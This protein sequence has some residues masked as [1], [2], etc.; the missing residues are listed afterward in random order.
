[1]FFAAVIPIEIVYASETLDAGSSGYGALLA[2]WGAGMVLGS[3]VFAGARRVSL[4][5]LLFFS[6]ILVGGSYLGLSAAGTIYVACA[7]SAAGGLG[8]GVQWVSIMSAVQELTEERFQARVVGLLES[9]GYAMPG[10]GFII[11][12]VVAE[13]IDP[14]ASF[15]VAGTGVLAVVLVATPLLRRFSWRPARDADVAP[16]GLMESPA[17]PNLLTRP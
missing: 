12:G 7:M 1:V 11:G 10:L 17:S 14:R 5:A 8:N 6:T 13:A 9:S 2:A 16:V 3:L 4:Q 15:F